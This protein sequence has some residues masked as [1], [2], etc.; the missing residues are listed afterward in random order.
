MFPWTIL[1]LA[2]RDGL[3]LVISVTR[4][5]MGRHF[6]L[7]WTPCAVEFNFD[8]SYLYITGRSKEIINKG[9]EVI[10]P[11]EIEEA[12]MTVAKERVKVCVSSF[13]C[14]HSRIYFRL[15]GASVCASVLLSF[16]S[17]NSRV[18]ALR[19]CMIYYGSYA[20][21]ILSFCRGPS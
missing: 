17:Q 10:S 6:D 2:V 14:L 4:I 9:G 18:L 3:T 11:F 12:I 20:P 7:F 15:D 1:H 8:I 16:L 5:R 21:F 19:S 13:S